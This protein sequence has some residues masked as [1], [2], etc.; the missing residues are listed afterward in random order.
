MDV[1]FAHAAIF[2]LLIER[3]SDPGKKDGIN[4]NTRRIYVEWK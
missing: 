4:L 1:Y 3:Q 2:E